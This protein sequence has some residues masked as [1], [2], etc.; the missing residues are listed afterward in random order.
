MQRCRGWTGAAARLEGPAER[1]RRG[2]WGRWRQARSA[3]TAMACG[4][5]LASIRG[6]SRPKGRRQ[7]AAS[8]NLNPPEQLPA[9]K[10]I[11]TIT[12]SSHLN[13]T[14]VAAPGRDAP[15][16]RSGAASKGHQC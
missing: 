15:N 7:A 11:T 10:A 8:A 5:R 16:G 9:R 3:G 1:R 12:P 4:H 13:Q 6:D 14:A 2:G